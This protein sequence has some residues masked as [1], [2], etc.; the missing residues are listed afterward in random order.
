MKL[1]TRRAAVLLFIVL[2]MIQGFVVFAYRYVSAAPVWAR[3]Y[4]NKH[5]YADGAPLVSGTIY[6]RN[7]KVLYQTE[8]G[9][10]AYSEDRSVRTAL[11]QTVGNGH[12]D[13]ATSAQVLYQA[14]L[15]GWDFVN[16]TYRFNNKILHTFS[17]L[18]LTLDADLCDVAYTALNGR[19]GTVGVYNYKTGEILCMVS[20]P[21]YDPENPPDIQSNPARYEGVYMN[22]FLS[23]VYTPGSV[24]KL[25]TAAAAIDN[26]KDIGQQV[27]HCDGE[28]EVAGELITCPEPHGDVNF[29]QALASSCNIAFAEITLQVGADTL[30]EYAEKTRMTKSIKFNGITTAAG[31]VQARKAT[32][33]DLAWA[34]IGQYSDTVNP[35]DFMT[36]MGAIANG[37]VSVRP[38][39]LPSSTA[40]E[41][42]L[43][44]QETAD[45]LKRLMRNNVVNG[46]GDYKYEGLELCAKTG[47]AETGGDNR[48]HAWFAGFLNR[49]DY[50]L[51]FVVVVENGGSGISAA[52]PVAAKVLKAAVAD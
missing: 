52:A 19:R 20:S 7:K 39:I 5:L 34:G 40:N 1:M 38:K 42:R 27:F 51:A 29:E 16:G 49:A 12:G 25:V 18:T 17:D 14:R 3:H 10:S 45:E 21:S 46:Y 33:A 13:V 4:S 41:D 37:G 2:L 23:A 43:L 24:F 50:P 28:E 9:T 35:L 22:R 8:N 6:D 36:Y 32:G 15:M 11:M 30:Q 48:P 47:T 44:S 31:N 26:V